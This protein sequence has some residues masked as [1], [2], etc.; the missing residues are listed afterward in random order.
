MITT[1]LL[2]EMARLLAA[3]RPFALGTLIDTRGSTPQKAGA[4]LLVR[5]DGSTLGTLGG[6]CVE[7]EAW[8]AAS[9]ALASD[10]ARV[11][12]F[13]LTED[14]AVDYGLACGGNER[15]FVAPVRG[16]T[17]PALVA[18][19][20]EGARRRRRGALVTVISPADSLRAGE[21]LAVWD[22]GTT[23]GAAIVAGDDALAAARAVIDAPRP[24]T[25]VMRLPDG[26]ELFVEPLA[27]PT[28]VIVV[29]GG[30]VG[31]AVASAAK[32]L[33]HAVAVI[34]DRSDF[35]SR[36]RFPDAD[37]L[38]VGDVEQELLAY[39]A[40]SSSAIVIVTRGHKWDYQAL[41][42]GA[43]SPAFYV[44]L[45]GSRRKVAL[46]YRQLMIDGVPEWRLRQVHAPIGL[47][48]GAVTPEEIGIS[49]IAEVT[50]ARRGGTGAPLT[51][52]ARIVERQHAHAQPRTGGA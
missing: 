28:E 12:D 46:I 30:H 9:E 48:I 50:Q 5:A 40:T 32:F 35:A 27:P 45:M 19:L 6:G 44:G 37:A 18:A 14:I 31:R 17:A 21:M 51:V 41:S 36:E 34:D 20:R 2:D 1:D 49:I 13:E 29:G 11:L 8:Q 47:D 42:A 33:G 43:R 26:A 23:Q 7:A 38:V 10:T 4:R 52:D 15:I 39:P 25:H 3:G 24:Q 16:T 22:D